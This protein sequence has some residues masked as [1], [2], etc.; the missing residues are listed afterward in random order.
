MRLS[1]SLLFLA[2]GGALILTPSL[3]IAD[4]HARHHSAHGDTKAADPH[5]A[6]KK[7]AEAI[8]KLSPEDQKLA[9]EQRFCPTMPRV[10]L[11][12]M[13]PPQKVIVDGKPVLVCCKHCTEEAVEHGAEVLEA[14]QALKEAS[15][16]LA[17]LP[18]KDR[19]AAEAQ[20]Y[21]AV[22]S[23]NLLGSMGTPIKIELEGKAVFLCCKGCVNKA[24]RN[25]SAT[26][27]KVEELKK[28]GQEPM[29]HHHDNHA[30]HATAKPQK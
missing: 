27:A 28:A 6:E 25:P 30:G 1:K 5:A 12:E 22:M 26:L 23:D 15:A 29:H 9:L 14:A 21:C 19:E 24:K 17:K 3:G 18:P 13:G 20:K 2:A 11:G 8:A 7:I 10:R 4:E 16:A